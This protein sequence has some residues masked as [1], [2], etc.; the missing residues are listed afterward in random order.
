MQHIHSYATGGGQAL[1]TVS[2]GGARPVMMQ[3]NSQ[4]R[5]NVTNASYNEMRSG[6]NASHLKMLRQQFAD[7]RNGPPDDSIYI[8]RNNLLPQTSLQDMELAHKL[9]KRT[10]M[11][12]KK[13]EATSVRQNNIMSNV[14]LNH[15]LASSGRVSMVHGTG[16]F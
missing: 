9:E 14:K 1:H 10:K 16:T 7:R 5:M 8:T 2:F 15:D 4:G 12:R 6:V 13:P 3:S 11:L